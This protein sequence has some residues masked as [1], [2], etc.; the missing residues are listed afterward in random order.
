MRR[1]DEPVL[2][3]PEL[4][5]RLDRSLP[6][7]QLFEVDKKCPSCGSPFRGPAFSAQQPGEPPRRQLCASCTQMSD[8]YLAATNRPSAPARTRLADLEPPRH[9]REPGED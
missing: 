4:P 1:P 2:R 9:V 7:G 5:P 6:L 3:A 8:T